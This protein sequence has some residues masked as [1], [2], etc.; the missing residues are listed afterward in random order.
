MADTTAPEQKSLAPRDQ[1]LRHTPEPWAIS[2]D[3]DVMVNTAPLRKIVVSGFSLSIAGRDDL[4]AA[5]ARRI[6]ACVNACAGISTDELESKSLSIVLSDAIN[7]RRELAEALLDCTN[8]LADSV[9]H[10]HP[11]AKIVDQ[12]RAAL[13]SIDRTRVGVTNES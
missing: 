13:A 8:A 11:Y 10:T 6:V 9:S 5:N 12:C 3:G 7:K 2:S 4:A 1:P